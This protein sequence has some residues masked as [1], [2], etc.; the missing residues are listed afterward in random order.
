MEL[1]TYPTQLERSYTATSNSKY[2]TT[3][4][5]AYDIIMY[6]A[7]TYNKNKDR[8]RFFGADF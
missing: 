8:R 5:V 3:L 7:G 1:Y 6:I 2:K 4:L